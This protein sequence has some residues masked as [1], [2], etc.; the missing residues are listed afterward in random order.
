MKELC[1]E[2]VSCGLIGFIA[3]S[4]FSLSASADS[5][6][7]PEAKQFEVK[8]ISKPYTPSGK[9]INR[10]NSMS[11]ESLED[12]HSTPQKAGFKHQKRNKMK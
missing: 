7:K 10:E 2:I 5:Q 1:K 9:R 8:Q 4:G 12:D 11:V 6:Q 3:I